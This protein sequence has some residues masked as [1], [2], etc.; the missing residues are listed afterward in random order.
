[1]EM[2]NE[3]DSRSSDDETSGTVA[4]PDDSERTEPEKVTSIVSDN[5]VRGSDPV[6]LMHSLV[7]DQEN[8]RR[9][10][11]KK[12]KDRAEKLQSENEEEK[13]VKREISESTGPTEKKLSEWRR[14]F[15]HKEEEKLLE[16][17]M[18]IP[19][20][21]IVDWENHE[22]EVQLP[23]RIYVARVNA[24]RDWNGEGD[25]ALSWG[26]EWLLVDLT[27]S[28]DSKALAE[29]FDKER[30]GGPRVLKLDPET[31]NN[32]VLGGVYYQDKIVRAI[33]DMVAAYKDDRLHQGPD[34]I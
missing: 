10:S 28:N 26:K 18:K 20:V 24:L 25:F 8:R 4:V 12:A 7:A 33:R 13:R 11:A 15:G 32:A 3:S 17:F 2:E 29:K 6:Q 9:Q 22:R 21:T 16:Y 27:T 30:N 1:M 14:E 19:V 23:G 34:G 31:L 5:P